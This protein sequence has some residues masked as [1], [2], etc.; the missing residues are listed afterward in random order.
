MNCYQYFSTNE[1]KTPI[2]LS[3]FTLLCYNTNHIDTN[4]LFDVTNRK[5][6]ARIVG[7]KEAAEGEYPWHV[8]IVEIKSDE[9][10]IVCGGALLSNKYVLTAAHCQPIIDKAR[11][12]VG[13]LGIGGI[14]EEEDIY[15]DDNLHKMINKPKIHP[16]YDEFKDASVEIHIYDFMILELEKDL[17]L[18][19]SNFVILPSNKFDNNFLLGKKLELSGWG[20]TKP[21]TRREIIQSFPPDIKTASTIVCE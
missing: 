2:K 14:L 3:C 9:R 16:L 18:D 17:G 13:N 5:G 6:S 19:R 10:L 7:G 15:N 12:M 21:I 20:S 11:L 8:A 1:F 4:N